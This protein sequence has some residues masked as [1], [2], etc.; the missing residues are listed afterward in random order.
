MSYVNSNLENVLFNTN[1][2]V[3]G[4]L[5]NGGGI[6]LD[7]STLNMKN[8]NFTKNSKNAIYAYDSKITSDNIIFKDN[9]EALHCV[10]SKTELNNTNLNNDT[11]VLNDTNYDSYVEGYGLEINPIN[12]TIDVNNLP[13]RYDSRDWGWVSPVK[14][15]GQMGACWT[16]GAIGALE[17]TLLKATGKLYDFSENN[18]QNS[19]LQYSKNGIKDTGEGALKEQA[20]QY[21]LSWIGIFPEEYD[22]YDELGKLSPT[23]MSDE[24]IHVLDAIFIPPNN[25][26]ID[27]NAIK[28][29]ILKCGSVNIGYYS[30]NN[31]NI[32]N[33]ETIA[34]YQNR[35]KKYNHAVCFVG[36][37]DNYS[38]KNFARTPPGDGAFIIKN[39]WGEEKGNHGYF[40]I[41]Y[42]DT[43]LSN[44]TGIGYLF[45][46]TEKYTKNYQTDLG[47]YLSLND[48]FE[49]YKN[50]YTSFGDD[51]INAVGTYFAYQGENYTIEIYVNDELK[52]TQNGTAPYYG[53]H[54]VKLTNEI[55][56]KNEDNFT[57][58]MTKK[59]TPILKLSRQHYKNNTSFVKTSE[60]WKD[61][62][63]DI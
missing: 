19:M 43:S 57:V 15:Q 46:N 34:T 20:T 35:T 54:T 38:A 50:K 60:G 30:S 32:L 27:F 4:F 39:S 1:E 37:D 7:Q 47:G 8:S 44:E 25:N 42:Y 48:S 61:T 33:P 59:T 14:R 45:E 6:Y 52:H 18:M 5:F 22:E 53:Y 26:S 23:I 63:L 12:N 11:L 28:Q 56:I 9:I 24:N 13:A 62:S 3:L 29:A 36:W 58:V 40:Y 21:L 49:S 41:S 2:I 31:P 17:S 10:F 51:L 16:F 55:Q